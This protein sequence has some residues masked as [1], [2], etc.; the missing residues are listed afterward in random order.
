M[1]V[2]YCFGRR[3]IAEQVSEALLRADRT[4]PS[5]KRDLPPSASEAKA[6]SGSWGTPSDTAVGRLEHTG[7][8]IKSAANTRLSVLV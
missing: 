7:R 6:R 1:P 5:K 2:L 8:E 3:A 4:P